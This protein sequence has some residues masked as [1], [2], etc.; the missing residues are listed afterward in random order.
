[1]A[2]INKYIDLEKVIASKNPKLLKIL[3]R[4]LLRYLKR[5]IHE[6]DINRAL[7]EFGH[8]QNDEFIEEVLKMLG[9]TFTIEGLEKLDSNQRYLFVSNHPLGGLDGMILMLALNKQFHSLK[10]P[11]NDLLMNIKQLE[12]FFIPVNKHGSQLKENALMTETTYASDIQMLSFP[13]GLCSRK[14]RGVVKDLEW[15]KNFVKKAI[16]HKRLV[17]PIFFEGKNS[18]FFYNLAR[19]RTSLGIKANIEML[20]LVDEMFKQKGNNFVIRV[21]TPIH[22]TVFDASQTNQWWANWVKTQVYALG[23]SMA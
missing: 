4:F 6:D 16:Q 20:Y 14:K 19:F 12:S 10:V 3:P 17:V 22:Y 18:N 15:K 5:I 21:G 9:V 7:N 11:A 13:A 2:E 23:A 8:K 1:M